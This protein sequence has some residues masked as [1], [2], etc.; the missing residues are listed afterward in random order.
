MSIVCASD[1]SSPRDL[2]SGSPNLVEREEDVQVDARDHHSTPSH[3]LG[4]IP[5]QDCD[6]APRILDSTGCAFSITRQ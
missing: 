6:S 5:Q 1:N 4:D 3:K 2:H